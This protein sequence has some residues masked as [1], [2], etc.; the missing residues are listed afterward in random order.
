M[1]LAGMY[2]RGY[3][4][5]FLSPIVVDVVPVVLACSCAVSCVKRERGKAFLLGRGGCDSLSHSLRIS[6]PIPSRR[7]WCWAL[8]GVCKVW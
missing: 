3:S 2:V 7:S 1:R 5:G 4:M 8:G 6:S